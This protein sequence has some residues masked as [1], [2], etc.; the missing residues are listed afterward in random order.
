MTCSVDNELARRK[1]GGGSVE[2]DPFEHRICEL[3]GKARHQWPPELT[4]TGCWLSE[5]S[6]LVG[7]QDLTRQFLGG[8]RSK[9]PAQQRARACSAKAEPD[10]NGGT[11]RYADMVH[12]LSRLNTAKPSRA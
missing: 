2:C 12:R 10:L 3:V 8:A 11:H 5:S 4:V 7:N 1:P 9:L 6:W